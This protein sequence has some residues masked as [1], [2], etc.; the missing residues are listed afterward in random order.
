MIRSIWSYISFSDL[1]EKCN[2][3]TL[4]VS[5][6]YDQEIARISQK[7]DATTIANGIPSFAEIKTTLYEARR[8]N[9]PDLPKTIDEIL[10]DD[11]YGS[12][13]GVYVFYYLIPKIRTERLHLLVIVVWKFY[14]FV[15]NGML[16]QH[17]KFHQNYSINA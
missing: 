7:Y 10:I 17:L 12:T 1:K 13:K 5:Q 11:K 2:K 4:P 15:L 16:M 9:F 14:K 8:A 6:L 3:E